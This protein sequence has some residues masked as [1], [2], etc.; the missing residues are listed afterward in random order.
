MSRHL[1][2]NAKNCALVG[3]VNGHPLKYLIHMMKS[4]QLTLGCGGAAKLVEL[5][6]HLCPLQSEYISIH[7]EIACENP[8]YVNYCWIPP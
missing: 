8:C 2:M 7:N 4:H 5:C 1:L 3:Y 6:C